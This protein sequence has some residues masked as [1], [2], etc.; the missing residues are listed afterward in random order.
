MILLK[1]LVEFDKNNCEGVPSSYIFWWTASHFTKSGGSFTSILD[2]V[3]EIS[4]TPIMPN[5]SWWPLPRVYKIAYAFLEEH[6][7]FLKAA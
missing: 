7:Q 5:T 3:D 2:D 1:I 6:R 4:K